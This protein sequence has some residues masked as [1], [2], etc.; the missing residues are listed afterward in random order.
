[1]QMAIGRRRA[2]VNCLDLTPRSTDDPKKHRRLDGGRDNHE[3]RGAKSW[4]WND[5]LGNGARIIADFP[6]A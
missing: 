1:M 6:V 4:E 2:Y 3:R 5:R